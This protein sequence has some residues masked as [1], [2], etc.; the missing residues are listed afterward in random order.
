MVASKHR[1]SRIKHT[2]LVL[3]KQVF[4]RKWF[5]VHI[6]FLDITIGSF[7]NKVIIISILIGS[8]YIHTCAR[9]RSR[10]TLNPHQ[11]PRRPKNQ[12]HPNTHDISVGVTILHLIDLIKGALSKELN[13]AFCIFRNVQFALN[14]FADDLNI[15]LYSPGWFR[16]KK[17]VLV[18]PLKARLRK[19]V[20]GWS[21]HFW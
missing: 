18:A 10:A 14:N 19:C 15:G 3:S 9:N 7:S 8:I 21:E 2:Y 20:G 17:F 1:I 12:L 6:L 13:V 5:I 4:W 16:A 11:E